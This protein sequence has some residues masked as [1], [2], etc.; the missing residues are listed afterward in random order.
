MI[1]PHD[2]AFANLIQQLHGDL[3]EEPLTR[4]VNLATA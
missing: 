4:I 1:K 2:K 3:P